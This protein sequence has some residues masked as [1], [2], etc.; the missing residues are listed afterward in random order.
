MH[1]LA[2]LVIT[3]QCKYVGLT[4]MYLMS[5][6]LSFLSPESRGHSQSSSIP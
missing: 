2:V 6:I 5:L 1:H 3:E 4:L